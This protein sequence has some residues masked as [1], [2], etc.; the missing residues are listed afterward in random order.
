MNGTALSEGQSIVP[1]PLGDPC[2]S[3]K[4]VGG[5]T[6]CTRRT[7]PVLAC[8]PNKAF[9]KPGTCCPV[10]S[11]IRKEVVQTTE[12]SKPGK[13]PQIRCH[14]GRKM[15]PAGASFQPDECTNCTCQSDSTTLCYRTTGSHCSFGSPSPPTAV[16]L[17]LPHGKMVGMGKSGR[18]ISHSSALA[19]AVQQQEAATEQQQQVFLPQMSQQ[20]PPGQPGDSNAGQ[21]LLA[22][23]ALPASRPLTCSYRGVTYQVEKTLLLS[24]SLFNA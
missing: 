19:L 3:C 7:C 14:I 20:S 5:S 13:R 17:L 24:F 22:P 11:G 23:T 2:T 6:V 18:T 1:D 8:P 21:T 16:S 15:Y 9:L 10:C 12:V 4:C